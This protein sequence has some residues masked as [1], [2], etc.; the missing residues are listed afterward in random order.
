VAVTLGR[1]SRR[2]AVN[3]ASRR[4]GPKATAEGRRSGTRRCGH[5]CSGLGKARRDQEV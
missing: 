4:Y 3:M 1:P 2:D 5:G